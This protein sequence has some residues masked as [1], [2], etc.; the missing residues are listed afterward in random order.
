MEVWCRSVQ[1]CRR[2]QLH[3]SLMRVT[4]SWDLCFHPW[5]SVQTVC[6]GRRYL[7]HMID[8][9]QRDDISQVSIGPSQENSLSRFAV[10]I[11]N[12]TQFSIA[13]LYAR[14]PSHFLSSHKHLA[15]LFFLA[16]SSYPTNS[17]IFL[18]LQ[19]FSLFSFGIFIHSLPFI[20]PPSIRQTTSF[21]S[22]F[23]LRNWTS[24][25]LL[26]LLLWSS[27]PWMQSSMSI[28]PAP[29]YIVKSQWTVN[30]EVRGP[31]SRYIMQV[32]LLVHAWQQRNPFFL[33]REPSASWKDLTCVVS[34]VS[35]SNVSA[36]KPESSFWSFGKKKRISVSRVVCRHFFHEK[37]I[38]ASLCSLGLLQ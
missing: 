28:A 4:R 21:F 24:S 29:N 20:L 3:V 18:F 36:F 9:E 38:R 19:L 14:I 31:T 15:Y 10:T 30:C 11:K 32:E 5:H 23:F 16:W 8:W 35:A 6:H 13:I 26:W 33:L 34:L 37:Y 25:S 17:L 22:S 2:V 12:S 7:F 27:P 1:M